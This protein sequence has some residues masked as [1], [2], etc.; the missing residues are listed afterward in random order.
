MLLAI[1]TF[2]PKLS[3]PARIG[4]QH[5]PFGVC[6]AAAAW[7]SLNIFTKEKTCTRINAWSVPKL[8]NLSMV[9]FTILICVKIEFDGAFRRKPAASWWG[10][11]AGKIVVQLLPFPWFTT[12]CHTTIPLF[13]DH[14]FGYE[15]FG[16]VP[17]LTWTGVLSFLKILGSTVRTIKTFSLLITNIFV[18][19]QNRFFQKMFPPPLFGIMALLIVF[20]LSQWFSVCKDGSDLAHFSRI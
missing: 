7:L 16:F 10:I 15:L 2:F 5:K 20:G 11:P 13:I 17:D 14:L 12:G 8:I 18:K 9:L 19:P 4:Y 6:H 1:G 3:S